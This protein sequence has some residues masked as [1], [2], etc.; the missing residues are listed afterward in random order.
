MHDLDRTLNEFETEFGFG[1]GEFEYEADGQGE[2][3][4]ESDGE[5]DEAEV[6]ALAAELLEVQDE[7]EL[8]QFLGKLIKRGLG[9]AKQLAAS[10]TGQALGGIM[11]KAAGDALPVIGQG[12]G[13]RFF[14]QA[15]ADAGA[16]IGNW[17]RG[18][19]GWELEGGDPE[20]EFEVAQQLVKTTVQAARTAAQLPAGPPVAVARRAAVQAAQQVAPQLVRT[21]ASASSGAGTAVGPA[22]GAQS[23][24]WVRKGSCIML[25][26][27]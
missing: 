13:G 22:G 3:L 6:A 16:R 23:G 8:D 1:A 12:I 4:G 11:K 21:V 5:M 10:P 9:A 14:G 7:A 25:L 2:W 17:A 24:R 18:K 26:G 20:M 15:G 27:I 19:L